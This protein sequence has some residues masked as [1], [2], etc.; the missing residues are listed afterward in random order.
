MRKNTT[1][2]AGPTASGK[3][4]LALR[5]A[6]AS[7]GV[8]VNADSM[9]VYDVLQVLTARPSIDEMHGVPHHLFG[10][11]PPSTL[12]STGSWLADVEKLLAEPELSGRHIVIVGGT[13]MYFRALLGGLSAMPEVSPDVRQFWRAALAQSG[14]VSLHAELARRDPETAARLKPQDSQRIVRAIEVHESSGRPIS[15]WQKQSGAPLVDGGSARKICLT[16]DRA[17]LREKI[18]RRFAAMALSGA[19][20]EVRELLAMRLDPALPA[21]KAIGVSEIGAFLAGSASIEEAIERASAA[22]RRYAKRQETW[23]RHQLGADWER[24]EM[25]DSAEL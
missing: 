10:H 24:V 7:D 2:I 13:G 16:P 21:M 22:T 11:V 5:I 25:S 3:S 14:P 15:F 12:Y 9:Q 6:G 20:D 23:L 19:A 18:N 8:V 1:L 4:R 17:A